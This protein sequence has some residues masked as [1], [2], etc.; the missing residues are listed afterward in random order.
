M[1]HNFKFGLV[2]VCL[3]SAS[4]FGQNDQIDAELA[5]LLKGD[6][7]AT[8]KQCEISAKLVEA[9]LVLKDAQES[10]KLKQSA[11]D[12]A[13]ALLM[14]SGTESKTSEQN[15]D[16][17]M[18]VLAEVMRDIKV[19]DDR[20]PSVYDAAY[21]A[22]AA[23]LRAR[24]IEAEKGVAWYQSNSADLLRALEAKKRTMFGLNQARDTAEQI[25]KS[26]AATV[27]RLRVEIEAL[28]SECIARSRKQ[29]DDSRHVMPDLGRD[30]V[31]FRILSLQL[32]EIDARLSRLDKCS[33]ALKW[34]SPVWQS[35]WQQLHDD[36]ESA[37]RGLVF[38]GLDL[39]LKVLEEFGK[40]AAKLGL[41][42]TESAAGLE[43]SSTLVAQK[44]GLQHLRAGWTGKGLPA[45]ALDR[46]IAQIEAIQRAREANNAAETAS[47]LH[48]AIKTSGE[49][50]KL[51]AESKDAHEF[52]HQVNQACLV[53]G[54]AGV[55]FVGISGAATAIGVSVPASLAVSPTVVAG[56]AVAEVVA[57][58]ADVAVYLALKY[59]SGERL[60]AYKAGAFDRAE[61]RRDLEET[62]RVLRDQKTVVETELKRAAGMR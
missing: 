2:I 28:R 39:A 54:K 35:T 10:L 55:L 24:R 5:A 11:L 30:A 12:A 1:E 52:A 36:D 7:A 23:Q 58:A 25:R 47:A 21:D 3:A 59:E 57:S 20:R 15:R 27:G 9:E 6:P 48:D 18:S 34:D 33:A 16:Q 41:K 61:K 40:E 46:W 43:W 13:N 56:A 53:L 44:E 26:A 29:S 4:A 50:N 42:L 51:V 14:D 32:A 37:H 45:V 8:A 19:H 60:A 22:E 17:W 31:R 38:A 49:L 62:M